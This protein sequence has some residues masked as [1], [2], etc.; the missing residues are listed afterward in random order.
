MEDK[1]IL[2]RLEKKLNLSTF[3]WFISI[4]TGVLGSMIAYMCGLNSGLTTSN[5]GNTNRLTAIEHQLANQS[6]EIEKQRKSIDAI[7]NTLSSYNFKLNK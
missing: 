6:S 2:E 4:L 5:L 3:I 7:Y 1:E